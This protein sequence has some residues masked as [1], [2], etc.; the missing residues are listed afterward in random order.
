MNNHDIAQLLRNIAA[1]YEI[2]GENRFR[3]T[4]YQQ[5]ADAIAATPADLKSLWQQN[6]LGDIPGVGSS[7]TGH[8]DEL[9]RTGKVKHFDE[10]MKKMP[11][12][13]F[14]LLKLRGVGPKTAYKLAT[15]L[16]KHY[17]KKEDVLEKLEGALTDELIQ[18]IEGFGKK[19]EQDIAESL[20]QYKRGILKK[21][22]L[23]L[24]EAD[25]I[26]HEMCAYIQKDPG[27]TRVDMLGSLRRKKE[28]IGDIDLACVTSD[29]DDTI[30]HFVSHPSVKQVVDQGD[31]GATVLLHNG[32]Q[33][34]LRVSSR[35]S[36]GAMLQYFTGSK[37]HNIRLREYA[38][39]K[40]LSLSEHGIKKVGADKILEFPT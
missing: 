6:K 18:T 32:V 35:E 28:T 40:G 2:L 24:S 26:G 17:P 16:S 29:P 5:A 33:V 4:A 38:L 12:G 25:A 1:A 3:I 14:E 11:D 23:L 22:R 13:M 8:L 9:F 15:I 30:H 7:I 19:S 39:S 36:Y 20:K 27:V 37:Y 10:I 34:D 31:K 21:K